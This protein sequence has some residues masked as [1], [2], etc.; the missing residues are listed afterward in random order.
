MNRVYAETFF[1]FWL[2]PFD[3]PFYRI[4]ETIF[5]PFAEWNLWFEIWQFDKSMREE[6][7]HIKSSFTNNVTAII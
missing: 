4:P 2:S 3:F 7:A 6:M 5:D 1:D